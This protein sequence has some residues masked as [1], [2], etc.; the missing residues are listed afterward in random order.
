MVDPTTA[1]LVEGE[2][3]QAAVEATARALNRDLASDGVLIV[4]MGG[5]TSIGH[6]AAEFGPAGRDLELVGL[7]DAAERS[8]FARYLDND[9]IHVCNADLE[10]E[11]LRA[12]GIEES[13][14]FIESQGELKRFRT[15]QKQPHQRDRPIGHHLQNYCGIRAGRKARYARGM[16]EWLPPERI[17]LPLR[18][19]VTSL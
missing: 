11:L 9:G 2:S 17:P 6:F 10:D 5:A 4:P 19:L 3:D 8:F 18:Q 16:V 7:C 12:L 15:M 1:L 14:A 13:I